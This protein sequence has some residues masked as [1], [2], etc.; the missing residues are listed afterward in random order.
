V[1]IPAYS[2]LLVIGKTEC[3]GGQE[4]WSSS[5]VLERQHFVHLPHVT[6]SKVLAAGYVACA[7][8]QY[9]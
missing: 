8:A 3:C 7:L 4:E 1:V 2:R 5:D 6:C 9:F